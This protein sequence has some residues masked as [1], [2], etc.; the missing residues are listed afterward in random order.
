ML[1]DRCSKHVMSNSHISSDMWQFIQLLY[2]FDIFPSPGFNILSFSFWNEFG[3]YHEFTPFVLLKCVASKPLAKVNLWENLFPCRHKRV[4]FVRNVVILVLTR[5]SHFPDTL[6]LVYL[7]ELFFFLLTSFLS[8]RYSS[9]SF[10]LDS[11]TSHRP[12]SGPGR[13][14]SCLGLPDNCG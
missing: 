14:N 4:A 10:R 7:D 11:P 9:N 13:F 2:V 5:L 6:Q 12:F 3:F 1:L 8:R